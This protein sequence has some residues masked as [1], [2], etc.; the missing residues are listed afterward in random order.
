MFFI[1]FE[2]EYRSKVGMLTKVF[3]LPEKSQKS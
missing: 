2:M 1:P 3:P